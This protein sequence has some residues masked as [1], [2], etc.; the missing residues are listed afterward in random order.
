MSSNDGHRPGGGGVEV[1]PEL[2]ALTRV[3]LQ[4]GQRFAGRYDIEALIGRGGMGA[5]YRVRDARLGEIVA[6]KLLALSDER[7]VERFVREVRLSR[8]VT[9]PNVARTYDFGEQGEVRYLTMEYV[10]GVALEKELSSGRG[11]PPDPARTVAIATQVAHGLQAAHAAGIVHRDLKPANILLEDGGRVVLTDFGIARAVRDRQDGQPTGAV[12]GTPRY[13]SPEQ[14]SAK[15]A[16]ARSDIYALGVILFQM[17]TGQLPFAGEDP[18]ADAVARIERSAPDP[19]DVASVPD[20]LAE[21]INACLRRDPAERPQGGDELRALLPAPDDEAAGRDIGGAPRARRPSGRSLSADPGSGELRR[22]AAT[23]E[24]PSLSTP[25]GLY[26]PLCPFRQA[27]AV[28]PFSYRGPEDHDY[29][30]DALSEELIDILSR[31]RG[32]RVLA[33]GATRRF[34]G[35]GEPAQVGEELGADVVVEGTAQL[36]GNRV[37]VSARLVE[38]DSGVQRWS[39][40]FDADFEDVFALQET[41]GQRVAES[42]RLEVDAAVYRRSAP[43]EAIEL[44]LRARRL[45][46]STVNLRAH[47]AVDMLDHCLSLAPEFVPA[48]PGHALASVRAWWQLTGEPTAERAERAER[49]VERARVRAPDLAET[50]LALAMF[51]VQRGAYAE[52]T[53][54]LA[55]ALEIAPTL[56]EAHQYLGQLQAEAGHASEARRRLQ[57][58]L[59]LDPSMQAARIGLARIAALNADFDTACELLTPLENTNSASPLASYGSALRYALWTGREAEVR[60]AYAAICASSGLEVELGRRMLAIAVGEGSIDDARAA[61]LELEQWLGNERLI[62]LIRQL[63]T[64]AFCV[65]GAYDRAWA[66]LRSAAEGALID[67]DWMRRCPLLSPLRGG[68]EFAGLLA[69]VQARAEVI[70]RR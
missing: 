70:W 57:L 25:S 46:R 21:A 14:A 51:S 37:R 6:L 4:V 7:A 29:L 47:E 16:D 48:L 59:E 41:L 60:S 1:A 19:R 54:A 9:H 42:L 52:A 44:Y 23:V 10:R 32:L 26:A 5:V 15:P 11:E 62:G 45:L 30:G 65:A 63:A 53:P 3:E 69:T 40:R 68:D 13:M 66:T 43:P 18:V 67:V 33:P 8:R 20:E 36:A 34:A 17:A 55:K 35:G 31:T 2:R 58:A 50:H 24:P 12:M 27:L 39:E 61:Q 22:R 64:E 56:A 38:T 28:L 49:S